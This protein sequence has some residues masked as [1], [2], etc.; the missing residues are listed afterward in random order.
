MLLQ[1]I[2]V[3]VW[4]GICIVD[5]RTTWAGTPK[6]LVAGSVAGLIMGDMTTGLI[7][8]GTLQL[9]WLTNVGIGAYIPPNEAIGSII[10]VSI[11]IIAGG[12]VGTGLAVAVPTA[13]LSQQLLMLT[14]TFNIS[15][16]HKAINE[17]ETGDFDRVAKYNFYGL[18]LAFLSGTIPVFLAVYFGGPFV[19]EILA[20][21]PQSIF[22]GLGVAAGLLPAVGLGMLLIMMEGKNMWIF[23]I[24]GFVLAAYFNLGTIPIALLGICV[25]FLY[26]MLE[27]KVSREDI[28]ELSFPV[29]DNQEEE[30]DL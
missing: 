2:L 23:F 9:M 7:I 18:P 1:S 19:E 6:A 30:Y 8:S 16:V 11:A 13:L 27:R 21:I 3:A 10:G 14:N 22:D 4:A 28:E 20:F 29:S 15:L 5:E 12:G 17:A 26:D 24:I 25:A